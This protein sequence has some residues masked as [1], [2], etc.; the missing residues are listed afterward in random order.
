M[1]HSGLGGGSSMPQQQR[2]VNIGVNIPWPTTTTPGLPSDF[3]ISGD[4]PGLGSGMIAPGWKPAPPTM[5][6]PR[7]SQ[8]WEG[9]AFLLLGLM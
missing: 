2:P 3:G 5:P 8:D 9:I 6:T 1:I 4:L 7:P